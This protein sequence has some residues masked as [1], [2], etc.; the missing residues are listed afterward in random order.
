MKLGGDLRAGTVNDDDLVPR[1]VKLECVPSSRRGDASAELDD[2]P[3][4]V[5][6]SA[7]SRT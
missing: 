2:D 4:H 5:V 6:Y 1:G 3:G 7:F